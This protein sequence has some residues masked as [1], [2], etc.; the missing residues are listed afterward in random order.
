MALT[1]LRV[2]KDEQTTGGSPLETDAETVGP[3]EPSDP[4]P[5]PINHDRHL[6]VNK[7][8]D[9]SLPRVSGEG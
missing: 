1:I 2:S 8:L 6:D 9:R 5:L 3:D 7:I 4:R